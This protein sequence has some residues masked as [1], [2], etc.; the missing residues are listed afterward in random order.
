MK[1]GFGKKQCAIDGN[2]TGKRDFEGRARKQL[3]ELWPHESKTTPTITMLRKQCPHIKKVRYSDGDLKFFLGKME[4]GDW[5][6]DK[7]EFWGKSQN[8][9]KVKSK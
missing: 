7:H 2:M 1:V 5:D 6:M 8:Y 4:G 3:L 9:P